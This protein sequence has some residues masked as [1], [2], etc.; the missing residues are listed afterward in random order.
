[1]SKLDRLFHCELKS[2]LVRYLRSEP[3]LFDPLL[4]EGLLANLC[5]RTLDSFS[6][7]A[8]LHR[9]LEQQPALM[10]LEGLMFDAAVRDRCLCLAALGLVLDASCGSKP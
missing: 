10:S 4:A 6:A 8:L 2:Q 1:M 9:G 7:R 5:D 3:A